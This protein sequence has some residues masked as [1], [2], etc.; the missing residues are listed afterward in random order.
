MKNTIIKY[1]L[2]SGAIAAGC[3]LII[4]LVL[5][6]YGFDQVGFDNSAYVGYSLIILSMAVIFFGI[7]AY[8]DNENEGKVTFTQGLLVGL[9][10][11]LISCICYSLMWMVVYYNFIPN[12]MDDYAAFSVKKLK[13]SG[14]SDLEMSKNAAQLQQFKDIY[15]TP[16]GVFAITLTE[17]LPIGILGALVSAFILK[18]K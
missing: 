10:I 2:I 7:K 4:T 14:A 15:K 8:R 17:P 5:K 3:Q 11:A 1:G 12:F 18:K 16:L 13:E 9:G 6:S